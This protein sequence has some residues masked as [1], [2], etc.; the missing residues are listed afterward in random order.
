MRLGGIAKAPDIWSNDR[1]MLRKQWNDSVPV[2]RCFWHAMQEQQGGSRTG[3]YVM[4]ANSVYKDPAMRNFIAL[5]IGDLD[6]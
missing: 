2:K 1:E 5:V 4:Q 3:G 6:S